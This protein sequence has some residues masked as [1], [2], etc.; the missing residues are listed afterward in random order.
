MRKIIGTSVAIALSLSA[1]G[2]GGGGGGGTVILPTP[3]PTPTAGC[4]L[5]EQQDFALATLREWYLFPETLPASPNPAAFTTVQD[6]I[7]SLTA[8]ARSQGR[9][10]FFTYI[11]SIAEETAFFSGGASAGFGVRLAYDTTARRVFIAEAF[12]GAPALTAGIDRGDEIVAIGAT[13]TTLRTVNDIFA[14]EGT[15]G[16]TNALGPTTAGTVR[17]LQLTGQGGARTLTVTKGTFSLS[18]I[19]SR[20]GARILNVSGRQ[21]GY[22]NMRTFISS[23]DQQLRDS[24]LSFRN[25]GV[26]EF[27]VDLRYNGG[28]LVSTA[29]L[30]GDLLG[31]NRLTSEIFSQERFRPEKAS[32]DEIHRFAPTAQSV[33]PVK[34][35]FI[36]T[37]STASASELVI[38]GMIPYLGSNMALVGA[39]T[40]G[41]PVGQIAIDRTA[42]DA[43]IRVV[44]FGTTNAANN[45]N[46]FNGLAS[47]VANTCRAADDVTLPL[48]DVREASVAQAVSFL[49][50]G[51]ATCTAISG[52]GGQ[53]TASRAPNA[54][55]D[56]VA[57]HLEML[58]PDQ[59]NV[60][61]REVPGLF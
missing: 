14:S 37:G 12:E 9:D 24:F 56:G 43:R 13:P 36:G 1:C 40:F 5:R 16:I 26:T 35:A 33:A 17:T 46:Y 11:T 3:T 47:S 21:I 42:C 39:N 8:T 54:V 53:G 51:S 15:S 2:S 27:I 23:A 44:A 29:N 60:A 6:Y 10:R 49:S 41:K 50:T 20:Y 34:I 48:G 25:A 28:G 57:L 58:M 31:R 7:D 38:N 61:Q 18:P 52:A 22:L 19:S 55:S 30:F 59:P 4:S 45:L 32:N